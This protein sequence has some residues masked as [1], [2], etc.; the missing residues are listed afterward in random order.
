[1]RPFWEAVRPLMPLGYLCLIT[2][3]WVFF[4]VNQIIMDQPRLFFILTGTL[5]SNICVSFVLFLLKQ[6]VLSILVYHTVPI[7]RGSN[8]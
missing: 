8:E 3:I 1:M 4:S 2:T 5:F 7:N 6:D